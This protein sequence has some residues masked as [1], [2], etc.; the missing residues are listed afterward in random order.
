MRWI[1]LF[2]NEIILMD[3]FSLLLSCVVVAG[4]VMKIRGV[5]WF[6]FDMSLL[7]VGNVVNVV[8]RFL[9]GLS[10]QIHLW[11]FWWR[12]VHWREHLWLILWEWALL[13]RLAWDKSSWSLKR[14][15]RSS[16]EGSLLLSRAHVNL[17]FVLVSL[18]FLL[19]FLFLFCYQV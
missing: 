16:I 9:I 6:F 15:L 4:V 5:I 12:L 1:K 10:I 17:M 2:S 19:L 11:I 14:W 8:V 7:T 13:S 3:V 18:F